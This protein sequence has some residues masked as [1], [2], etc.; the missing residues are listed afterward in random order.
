LGGWRVKEILG[1]GETI[2]RMY[3]VKKKKIYFKILKN[4][5]NPWDMDAL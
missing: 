1:G 3:C 4:R 2:A 5:A